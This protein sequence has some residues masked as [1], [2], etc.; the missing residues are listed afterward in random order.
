MGQIYGA[1]L[2]DV[3]I[4]IAR[5]RSDIEKIIKN[6]ELE[7]EN[8][9]Q[10]IIK[11]KELLESENEK[12]S[13][14]KNNIAFQE[15]VIYRLERELLKEKGNL[16]ALK[17]DLSLQ[18]S[19]VSEKETSLESEINVFTRK[20]GEDRICSEDYLDEK[21]SNFCKD[22]KLIQFSK[23]SFYRNV[24]CKETNVSPL[25]SFTY[26]SKDLQKIFK[27]ISFDSI[28]KKDFSVYKALLLVTD[29][30]LIEELHINEVLGF[31]ELAAFA[32]YFT[33]PGLLEGFLL[34]GDTERR[35]AVYYFDE[36]L[37]LKVAVIFWYKDGWCIDSY[38]VLDSSG[39]L[40]NTFIFKP[41]FIELAHTTKH[42]LKWR[43]RK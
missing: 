30:E 27:S 12:V 43:G 28:P 35:I 19:I 20:S 33:G 22:K 3:K 39:Q 15:D 2:F 25:K 13:E 4:E 36:S 16:G 7:I 9:K 23:T 31:D 38:D 21:I 34:K 18:S 1:N 40:K 14:I 29:R 8:Q 11:A 37:N 6:E 10:V 42:H 32:S 17:N 41:G 5:V 26:I 24:L